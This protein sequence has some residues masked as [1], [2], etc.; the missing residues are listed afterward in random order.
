M[1]AMRLR[2]P[3]DESRVKEVSNP[4]MCVAMALS[5]CWQDCNLNLQVF[6][7]HLD[8]PLCAV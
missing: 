3:G 5:A 8:E 6:C 7:Q 1:N 2:K 4:A